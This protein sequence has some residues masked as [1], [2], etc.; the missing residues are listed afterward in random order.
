MKCFEIGEIAVVWNMYVRGGYLL[1]V[2]SF[3]VETYIYHK[4]HSVSLVCLC[5]IALCDFEAQQAMQTLRCNWFSH[6]DMA[7][8]LKLSIKAI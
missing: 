7:L 2:T 6:I 4:H 5:D 1:D 3:Y 8:I